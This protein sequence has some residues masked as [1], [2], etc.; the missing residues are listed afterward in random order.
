MA[1]LFYNG[2]IYTMTEEMNTVNAVLIHNGKVEKTG[3]YEELETEANA[4]VDLDGKTMMPALTDVHQHLVMIGKKLELLALDDVTDI[5]EMKQQVKAFKTNRTW[6]NI[7]GY[8]ENNFEDQYKITMQEL[9][10][11]TDKPTLITRICAHAGVVNKK[12]FD[13][14]NITKDTPDPEGGYFE[15]DENG[16]LTGWVYDKAFE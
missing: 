12:A 3:K 5:D 8:D 14:L 15:R 2:T 13:A 7:L 16:E 1:T 10:E 11:L 6:N 4:F 9:D